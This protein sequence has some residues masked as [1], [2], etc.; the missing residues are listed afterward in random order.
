MR[1]T[2]NNFHEVAAVDESRPMK[3][4]IVLSNLVIWIGNS[5]E[6]AILVYVKQALSDELV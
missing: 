1:T 2:K 5:L 3:N 6:I 4:F